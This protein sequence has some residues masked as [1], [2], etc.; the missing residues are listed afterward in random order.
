MSEDKL[1]A[2]VPHTIG[3]PDGLGIYD[4]GD[5]IE[6]IAYSQQSDGVLY[7]S[8]DIVSLLARELATLEL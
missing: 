8:K 7:I 1:L 5:S 2:R 4:A 3:Q 6:I